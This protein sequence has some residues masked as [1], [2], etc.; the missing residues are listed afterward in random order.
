VYLSVQGLVG[1][2]GI[3][4]DRKFLIEFIFVNNIQIIIII[5][6][7]NKLYNIHNFTLLKI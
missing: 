4:P 1:Q 6:I 3:Q 5:I 7:N 2:I